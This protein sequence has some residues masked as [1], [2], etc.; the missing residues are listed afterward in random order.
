[1]ITTV[2]LTPTLERT[3]VVHY[4][5]VGYTN[6]ISEPARLDVAGRSINI[7]RALQQLNCPVQSV[8]L[9]GQDTVGQ[10]YETLLSQESLPVVAV[11]TKTHTRSCTV[12]WDDKNQLETRLM[13]PDPQLEQADIVALG[14]MLV[15]HVQ[16]G[17][18]VVFAG[19]LPYGVATDSFAYLT[20]V[21]QAVGAKVVLATNGAAL[22]DALKAEPDLVVLDQGSAEAYFNYPIRTYEDLLDSAHQLRLAGSQQVLISVKAKGMAVLVNADEQWMVEFPEVDSVGTSSGVWDAMVAGYLAGRLKRHPLNVALELGAAA[23]TYANMQVGNEFGTL[24]DVKMYLD[25]VDV[26]PLDDADYSTQ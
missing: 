4:L 10:I 16:V 7:A 13:E 6:E 11:P 19:D 18:M 21:V 5:G 25:D 22:N 2:T 12:I 26:T 24:K 17:D 14:E 9:L 8:I 23:A 20:D 1:M 15:Q 3:L